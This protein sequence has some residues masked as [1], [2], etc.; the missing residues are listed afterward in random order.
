M[1]L[2]QAHHLNQVTPMLATFLDAGTSLNCLE[3][4][5]GQVMVGIFSLF[6]CEDVFRASYWQP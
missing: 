3:S 4:G 6:P 2:L 5:H 1:E